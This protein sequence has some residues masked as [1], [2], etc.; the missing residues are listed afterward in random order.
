MKKILIVSILM[1]VF[2]AACTKTEIKIKD[3]NKGDC[4]VTINPLGDI[5]TSYSPLTKANTNNIYILQVTQND[6]VYASGLFDDLSQVRVYLHKGQ[7]YKFKISAAYGIK[8]IDSGRVFYNN[9]LQFFVRDSSSFDLKFNFGLSEEK[10]IEPIGWWHTHDVYDHPHIGYVHSY[11]ICT[12][13][14]SAQGHIVDTALNKVFNIPLNSLIYAYKYPY[15]MGTRMNGTGNQR[16]LTSA[17]A[18]KRD[19]MDILDDIESYYYYTGTGSSVSPNLNNKE[20][21]HIY[22]RSI[23]YYSIGKAFVLGE[24]N[25]TYLDDWFYGETTF[26]P[27]GEMEILDMNFKRVG[28]KLKYELNGVTDGEVTVTIKTPSPDYKILIQNTTNTATYSGDEIFVPFYDIANAFSNATNYQENVVVSV[29][30]LRGIGI[31]QD[32]GSKTIQ[33]KR[34]NLNRVRIE[35][36]NND[37]GAAMSMTTEV[38]S[39]DTETTDITVE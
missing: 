5:T 20:W 29:S 4:L 15:Y 26:T 37:Q 17:I 8:N 21:R 6:T 13:S 32:L 25:P 34:N 38:E 39:M 10:N 24:K 28:Y 9:K 2:C 14:T 3:H 16:K 11:N 19:D 35:L 18:K 22:L 36:G 30:W 23:K 12:R 7:Q 31:T 33:V 1:F 27:T